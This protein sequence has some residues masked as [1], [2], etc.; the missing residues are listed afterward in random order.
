MRAFLLSLVLI[1]AP[2]AR[3]STVVE[4]HGRLSV[5]GASIVDEHG[6]PVSFAGMSLFWSQW[7]GGF[8]NARCIDWLVRDWHATII[9]A[10]M[11]VE[12]GGYLEHPARE[13]AKVERVV[14]ACIADGVYVIID[15]H[16]HHAGDHT[17]AAVR[18]FT[19]MARR[20]HDR[21]NVIY[22]IFN[23]PLAVSWSGV[24]KPYA[25][26]VIDA[27]RAVDPDNLI[28]VGTPHWSQDVDAAAAD[29]LHGTNLVYALHFYAGSHKAWLRERAERVLKQGIPLMVTEWG[30]CNADGNGPVDAV[31]T[32]EWM[33]F[34]R[35]WRLTH[36]NWAVSDKRETASI[37]RPGA[38]HFGG[39]SDA[40]LTPS[41]RLARR[42]IHYWAAAV[43]PAA[44]AVRR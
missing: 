14:D 31:S 36:C 15:W 19:A 34:M 3:A 41:G 37:V 44:P 39:W 35:R 21:P 38:S 2:L 8:W 27:I 7:K 22:E 11:G 32:A 6:E 12:M 20:Y 4:Q 25:R 1:L 10:A 40:E 42:W 5:R 28:V 26:T 13:Q 29:P 18:F 30:T 24:V 17:A 43:T 9:R 16:D 23:E 33:A